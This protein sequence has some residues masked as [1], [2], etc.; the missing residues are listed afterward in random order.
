MQPVK[1]SCSNG[2]STK[3]SSSG[4]MTHTTMYKVSWDGGKTSQADA[5]RTLMAFT[6]S[7]DLVPASIWAHAADDDEVST[8]P[9]SIPLQSWCMPTCSF[10]DSDSTPS[11]NALG[12]A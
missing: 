7:L 11:R 12:W 10:H 6:L 9:C 4:R 3:N 8:P 1:M 5:R 2:S